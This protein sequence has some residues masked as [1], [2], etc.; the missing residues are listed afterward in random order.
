MAFFFPTDQ[1]AIEID[2]KKSRFLAAIAPAH[3]RERAEHFIAQRRAQFRDATHHANA[4]IAGGPDDSSA[5]GCS[6]DGEVSGTAG[7][8]MLSVLQHT[9]LVNVVLVVSRFYGGTL[10]GTGGLVRAYQQAASQVI[11]QVS[12]EV[13]Q[14]KTQIRIQFAY[15]HE[16]D[17]LYVLSQLH[18]VIT[19]RAY[20]EQINFEVEVP[21]SSLDALRERIVLVGRG[22]IQLYS[23][24]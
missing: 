23:N 1:C 5:T 24:P 7:R 22:D 21:V 16:T 6:D 9:N 17:V 8:P 10:L 14:E 3:S 15:P 18:A 11:Q 20:A 4:F 2:V 19:N 13:F 12:K